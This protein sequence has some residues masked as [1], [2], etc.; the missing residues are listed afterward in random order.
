MGFAGISKAGI[1]V[2]KGRRG[3]N[4]FERAFEQ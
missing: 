3:D 4:H 2:A 1:S